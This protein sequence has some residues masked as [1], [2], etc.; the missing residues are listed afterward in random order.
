MHQTAY[1]CRYNHLLHVSQ[2]PCMSTVKFTNRPQIRE[3]SSEL[4]LG[5]LAE[6]AEFPLNV[7]RVS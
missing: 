2:R 1:L 5:V 4:L 6:R 7:L 3:G